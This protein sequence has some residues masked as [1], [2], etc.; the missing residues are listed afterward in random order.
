MPVRL[1][2]TAIKAAVGNAA[3]IGRKDYSDAG[4]PGLRLRIAATGKA[5]WVLA[6]RDQHSRMRRFPLGDWP[7]MG[8]SEAREEARKLRVDVRKGADP[9]ADRRQK[10]AL[11]HNAKDGLGTLAALLEL[12]EVKVGKTIKS[13]PPS[14]RRIEVVFKELLKK[15]LLAIARLDLQ[16]AIDSY[17]SQQQARGGA[18]CLRPV[19]KWASAR[20]YAL[21]D[22]AEVEAPGKNRRRERVLDAAE[23]RALLPVLRASTRPYAGAMRVM[24]MTLLRREEVCQ[25]RW[26]D[27]DLKAGT[28]RVEATIAK[29]KVEHKLPLSR[30]TLNFLKQVGPGQPNAFVFSTRTGGRLT[31]WDR[32]TKVI[33]EASGTTG[34]TRHDLRRTGATML[35][36]MGELPHVIE[37]ALNHVSVHSAIATIYNQSRYRPQVGE[38]LQRLAD[39]L[40]G[41]EANSQSKVISI[42]SGH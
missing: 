26:R 2:E 6:C 13:W 31:N 33:M 17:P 11:G 5:G 20:G 7:K 21:A 23:L 10:R 35:G 9:V 3:T 14:K 25:A 37:A 4:L 30:Q 24:L 36:E 40:D 15:P 8:L 1:T 32:D 29:N 34:W 19:L 18:Y 28:W 41:I 22:L 39:A 16:I 42:R 27:V 12:Y 38:A